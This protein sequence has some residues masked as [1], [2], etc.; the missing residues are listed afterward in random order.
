MARKLTIPPAEHLRKAARSQIIVAETLELQ[1]AQAKDFR[2]R[3]S[4]RIGVAI[5]R[6]RAS[7]DEA[8]AEFLEALNK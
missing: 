6:F 1:I 4:H 3:F 5:L 8:T 7:I 2:M